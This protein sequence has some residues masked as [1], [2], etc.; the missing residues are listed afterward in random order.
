[1]RIFVVG[2]INVGKSHVVNR[3]KEMFPNYQIM[4]IDEYRKRYGDGTLDGEHRVR[5]AFSA[6][7]IANP[8]AIIEFSGGSNISTLFVDQLR[9]NSVIVLEVNEKLEVC[10]E[11][12][13]QKNFHHI[14]Y[15]PCEEKLEETI[16]RLDREF[17]EGLIDHNF[18]DLVLKK[19]VIHS[20][21]DLNLLPLRQYD[22]AIQL[23]DHFMGRYELLYTFGSMAR[24][25]MNINSDVDLFLK[26]EKN[27]DDVERDIKSIYPYSDIIRQHNQ[28]AIYQENLLLE[29]N[30]IRRIED[31][32][33]FYRMSLIKDPK[34]TLL[35]GDD[36]HL[37]ELIKINSLDSENICE[38]L[39]NTMMRLKYYLKSLKRVIAKGDLYKYYFH[40]NIVIH[41]YVRLTYLMTGQTAYNYLPRHAYD[42]ISTDKWNQLVFK[43]EDDPNEHERIINKMVNQIIMEATIY[44]GKFC[45]NT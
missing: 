31:S 19:Y 24:G 6:D 41:E 20:D 9:R 15:P 36:N 40:T 13:R 21:D 14:P 39:K 37:N 42:L 26:T 28:F 3:L 38:S 8:N 5:K 45:N 7:I 22:M 34:K 12:I 1:M 32:Q 29:I 35:L 16:V 33:R 17:K 4:M 44:I 23:A 2:N 11:R 25:T 30:V 10:I 18:K 27:I 43:F